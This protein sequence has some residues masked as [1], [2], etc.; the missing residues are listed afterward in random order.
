M[1][2]IFYANKQRNALFFF[3]CKYNM[4]NKVWK[5]K[6]KW[7]A[8]EQK[9][10]RSS[11]MLPKILIFQSKQGLSWLFKDKFIIFP[12]VII[13][14]F[15]LC[16]FSNKYLYFLLKRISYDRALKLL[17]KKNIKIAIIIEVILVIFRWNILKQKIYCYF[18]FLK[19]IFFYILFII[20]I[21]FTF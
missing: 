9:E 19:F 15:C 17:E 10:K 20:C 2:A 14:F 11:E 5:W 6:K 4:N 21:T 3:S 12:I 16:L 1:Y 7:I 8:I 18:Q 13:F